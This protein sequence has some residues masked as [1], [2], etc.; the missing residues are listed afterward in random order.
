MKVFF[1]KHVIK[2]TEVKIVFW[3]VA[4]LVHQT[5]HRDLKM[6]QNECVTNEGVAFWKRIKFLEDNK[7]FLS[8]DFAR[9][10]LDTN[11]LSFLSQEDHFPFID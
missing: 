8:K 1:R 11:L 9:D 3:K 4:E 5:C 10:S 6:T 7:R 2:E